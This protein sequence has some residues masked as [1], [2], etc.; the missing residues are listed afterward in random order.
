LSKFHVCAL[1]MRES[2]ADNDD[3]QPNYLE[4]CMP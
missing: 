1:M 4:V 3:R 2:F